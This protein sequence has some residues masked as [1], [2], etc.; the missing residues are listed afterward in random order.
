MEWAIRIR[1]AVF[2]LLIV[3]VAAAARSSATTDALPPRGVADPGPGQLLVV[4]RDRPLDRD[5]RASLT[6]HGVEVL[7]YV[8]NSSYLVWAS[9][10]TM[11]AVSLPDGVDWHILDPASKLAAKIKMLS[12]PSRV[13]LLVVPQPTADAT[14]ESIR[15][16]G[17]A[18]E[19]FHPAQPDGRLLE[20]VARLDSDSL[21]RVTALST[22]AW[23]EPTPLR[24]ELGGE[25]AVSE[26]LH[27][28]DSDDVPQLGASDRLEEL[29]VDGHGIRWAVVDSG[30]DRF[31]PD[32]P[33]A[34]GISVPGCESDPPGDEGG[35]SG[36]GTPVAGIL[37][38]TAATGMTDDAGFLYG[39]GTAPGTRIV[40]HN[41][42]CLGPGAAWPP[43]DGWQSFSRD[44][45]RAG[46]VG[47][48][49]SWNSPGDPGQ[50]YTLAE[51]TH[52]FMVRD[53]DFDTPDVAEP[54]IM[55]FIAGNRG[56]EPHSLLAPS[57]AK[58]LIVVGATDGW[59]ASRDAEHIADFSSR[60]P[61]ADGRIAP[62][63]VAP[64]VDVTAPRHRDGGFAGLWEIA[65]TD[66]RYL[67]F[68][69]TSAAAPTVSG[70]LA[71]WVETW[72][73]RHA[74]KV[75]SQAMAR[76]VLVHTAEDVGGFP[77]PPNPDEGWGRLRA[78]L[79]VR[80][81]LSRLELDQKTL[82]TD[83][84]ETWTATYRV[85][86]P[87]RPLVVT[88]AWSDTPAMP[89]ADPALVN[90]LDLVVTTDGVEYLGNG[91]ADGLAIPDATPDRLNTV[92]HVVV[93]SPGEL[94]EI[95]V[96]AAHLPGDGVPLNDT[97]TDQDFALLCD[98]CRRPPP[99][100]IV[101]ITRPIATR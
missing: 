41:G 10:T 20:I 67:M 89:G 72:Q 42:V 101:P 40:A 28:V 96:T 88:V 59:R 51:R 46:A 39:L 95:R 6:A 24:P 30:V 8:P 13:S 78:D 68:S 37:A 18:I 94:V 90:D 25:E 57:E 87:S 34:T 91:T 15:E 32:L 9:P 35:P 98:N 11:K 29:G 99:A 17:A 36:H 47:S 5:F 97:L 60:G 55:V 19:S 22:V 45:L 1:V 66:G 92:E 63:V 70:A 83:T 76:A 48:N 85:A 75:P 80:P 84:G 12:L 49:N 16:A 44:V 4:Q 58:N 26:V 64:G 65:G 82:L 74:G 14:L 54:L 7:Q 31:H 52:D 27:H 2:S 3:T 43:T 23:V 56:G 77:A 71:L 93:A 53:G 33:V 69:G 86:D 73:S 38:G 100:P 50:G 61:T 21:A 81:E 79:M 62:T